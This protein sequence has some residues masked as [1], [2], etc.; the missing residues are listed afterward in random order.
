M[1]K[2]GDVVVYLGY[3]KCI[4]MR[5]SFS[6]AGNSYL[7]EQIDTNKLWIAHEE[8]VKEYKGDE[9]NVF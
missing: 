1:F 4:V 2:E 6:E 5:A 3:F 8:D 9:W 7:L